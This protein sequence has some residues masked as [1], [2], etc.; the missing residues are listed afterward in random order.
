MTGGTPVVFM[1]VKFEANT[2]PGAGIIPAGLLE[3][4]FRIKSK[5]DPDSH[6]NKLRTDCLGCSATRK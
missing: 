4:E 3:K 6:I 2:S 1:D 5:G